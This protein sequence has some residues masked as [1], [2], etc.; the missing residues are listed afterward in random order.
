LIWAISFSR[1][2]G[3]A[4]RP[5]PTVVILDPWPMTWAPFATRW[6]RRGVDPLPD[7]LLNSWTLGANRVEIVSYDDNIQFNQ[8]AERAAGM[9]CRIFPRT[10]ERR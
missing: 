4:P 8:G 5:P 2:R 3:A 1:S 10:R 9:G 6:L 7:Q